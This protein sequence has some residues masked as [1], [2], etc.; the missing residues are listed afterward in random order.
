[1]CRPE[2]GGIQGRTVHP[3]PQKGR[4]VMGTDAGSWRERVMEN[5]G[6]YLLVAP[7][8]SLKQEARSEDEGETTE[9]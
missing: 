6:I 1:M 7:L 9:S 4:Q 3:Q 8:F 2:G 5:P